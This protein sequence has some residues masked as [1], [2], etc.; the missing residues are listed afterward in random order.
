[1]A[2]QAEGDEAADVGQEGEGGQ[3][4]PGAAVEGE[5][6]EQLEVEGQEAGLDAPEDGPE[7]DDDG[8]LEAHVGLGLGHER[9]RHGQGAGDDGGDVVEAGQL[10]GLEDAEGQQGGEGEEH[11]VV[12]GREPVRDLEADGG[13]QA[14]E[15]ERGAE[16]RPDQGQ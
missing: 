1:V 10:D 13:A 12:L 11:P 3:E 9:G 5:L 2:R 6:A 4:V 16:A 15:E 14:H 8:E 7:E